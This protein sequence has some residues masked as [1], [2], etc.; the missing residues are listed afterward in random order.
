MVAR[1]VARD[2]RGTTD[3]IG[4]RD[5]NEFVKHRFAGSMTRSH[6]ASG[7]GNVLADGVADRCLRPYV[8]LLQSFVARE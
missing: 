4:A 1:N 6:P 7:V 2:P 5:R 8:A 3:R